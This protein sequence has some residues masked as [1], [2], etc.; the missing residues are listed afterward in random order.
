MRWGALA[1]D[2][3]VVEK[4]TNRAQDLL[5][6]AHREETGSD[7]LLVNWAEVQKKSNSS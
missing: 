5:D 6:M 4:L 3:A 2:P 7:A 1:R